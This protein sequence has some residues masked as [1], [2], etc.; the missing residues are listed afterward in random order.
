MEAKQL[1]NTMFIPISLCLILGIVLLG[2]GTLGKQETSKEQSSVISLSEYESSL[3]NKIKEIG[4]GE[5][6]NVDVSNFEIVTL[7]AQL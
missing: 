7:Y 6:V 1:K 2:F 5:S 4:S 3:E